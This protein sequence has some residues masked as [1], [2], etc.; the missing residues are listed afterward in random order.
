M[1]ESDPTIYG[2]VI[3]P[4][5]YGNVID[6]TIYMTESKT[7]LTALTNCFNLYANKYDF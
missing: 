7:Q 1:A 2:K 3:D 5:I 6:P 4:T